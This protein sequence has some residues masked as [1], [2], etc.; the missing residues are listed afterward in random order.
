MHRYVEWCGH[1]AAGNPAYLDP[2]VMIML[3]A[4]DTLAREASR[5]Q[6]SDSA[7]GGE[8]RGHEARHAEGVEGQGTLA[9]LKSMLAFHG[10][11]L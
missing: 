5:G 3:A 1:S 10:K 11:T 2:S 9:W 8:K 6:R 4:F 7:G